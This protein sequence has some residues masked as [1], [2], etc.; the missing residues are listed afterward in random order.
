M[1]KAVSKILLIQKE[2]V[3]MVVN[4]ANFNYANKNDPKTVH[5]RLDVNQILSGESPKERSNKQKKDR[6]ES[7]KK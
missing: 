7:A 3:K 5:G 2:L 1:E 4:G 6:N